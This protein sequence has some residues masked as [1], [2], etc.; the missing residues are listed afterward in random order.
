MEARR[1]SLGRLTNLPGRRALRS[2]GSNRLLVLPFKLST[3]RGRVESSRS[4]LR[5]FGTGYLIVLRGPDYCQP[6]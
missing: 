5:I 4:P 1:N 6:S 2:V 3:V